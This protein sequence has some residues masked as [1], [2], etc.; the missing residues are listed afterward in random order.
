VDGEGECTA[1]PLTKSCTV[2]SGH[3]QRACA[4]DAACGG[5]L[6]SCAAANRPCFLTGTLAPGL[7]GTGTLT[8]QG[9]ADPPVNDTSN[10]TLAAV[11]CIGPTIAGAVNAAA[12]LPGPGRVTINGTAV[13][14]P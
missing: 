9:M 10:P 14:L 12:G 4:N 3:A 5:A 7:V 6:N 8:A 1:G 13:G 2:A 11:F